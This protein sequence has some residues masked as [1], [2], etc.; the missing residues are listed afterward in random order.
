MLPAII[1]KPNKHIHV[2]ISVKTL[3][4]STPTTDEPNFAFVQTIMNHVQTPQM[5]QAKVALYSRLSARI[6]SC[7]GYRYIGPRSACITMQALMQEI[8]PAPDVSP[9][10]HRLEPS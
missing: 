10:S 2:Y 9:C 5:S 6:N 8:H 1:L 7:Y 3:D 4:K